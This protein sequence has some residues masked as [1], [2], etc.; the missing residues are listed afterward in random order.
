MMTGMV[1]TTI[2]IK[3]MVIMLDHRRIKVKGV[4]GILAATTATLL[5]TETVAVVA[6]T[7]VLEHKGQQMVHINDDRHS[8][9]K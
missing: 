3:T 8:M 5:M 4:R 6:A 7:S 1:T 2:L 9:E